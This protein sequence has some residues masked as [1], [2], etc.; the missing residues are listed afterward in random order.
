VLRALNSACRR[1]VTPWQERCTAS[2]Q[3]LNKELAMKTLK[4]A[5]ALTLMA[6]AGCATT[7]TAQATNQRTAVRPLNTAWVDRSISLAVVAGADQIPDAQQQLNLA[8]QEKAQAQQLHAAGDQRAQ[9]VLAR[10]EADAHLAQAL[11]LR[12][13]MSQPNQR[14]AGMP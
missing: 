12:S 6:L 3:S 14:P 10:A 11:A 1:E 7:S 13:G 4:W 2:P 8:R 5:L 9:M